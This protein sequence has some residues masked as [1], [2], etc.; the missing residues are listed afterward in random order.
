[1][2]IDE[3]TFFAWLDGELEASAARQVADAVA[4][5]PVLA[6]RAHEHRAMQDKLRLAFNGLLDAPVPDRIGEAPVDFAAAKAKRD[7]RREVPV[8]LPQWAAMAA[9]LVLGLGIGAIVG[10]GRGSDSPVAAV[11]GQ[12][13]AAAGLERALDTQL[14]SAQ[15]GGAGPRIGLTFRNGEGALCRS[16]SGVAGSSGL[17][18]RAG[19]QWQ[20]KGLFGGQAGQGGDYRMAAGEDPR[21][22][23]LIEES[24]AGEPFDAA[25]ERAAQ[26]NGW[27]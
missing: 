7:E 25:A 18:C 24:I 8:R 13:V 5:D 14:A 22:A 12:M 26:E 2:T 16:F 4:A 10:P 6:R 1:M 19:G 17:A 20:V 3:E 23:A 21:L 27:R 11:Q 15:Q 9:T